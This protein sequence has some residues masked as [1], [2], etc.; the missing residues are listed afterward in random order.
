[1]F[2]LHDQNY[3]VPC[4]IHRASTLQT[5]CPIHVRDE[6]RRV[7][8]ELGRRYA[9]IAGL[10]V[11]EQR[12]REW[13]RLNGL[14]ETRPLVWINEI[15]WSEME[16]EDELTL[17]T[18]S[19]FSKRIE[20]MLRMELYKWEHL[21]ADMVVEPV[22]PSPKIISNSGIGVALDLQSTLYRSPSQFNEIFFAI[23]DPERQ[24][25]SRTV[26]ELFEPFTFQIW[27]ED[28]IEKIQDP[29]VEHHEERTEAFYEAYDE[30]FEGIIDVEP[31]G[32][33]G[34][35]F[36]PWDDIAVFADIRDIFDAMQTRPGYVHALIDRVADA[37]LSALDQYEALGLLATN[38]TNVR[39]GSGGYG[40]ADELPQPDPAEA[41]SSGDIWGAATAQL[42]GKVA[43]DRFAE[44]ALEYEMVWLERFGLSYYGCCESLDEK[45]EVLTRIP[46]LRKV[47]VS[48]FASPAR[49]AEVLGQDY[50]ISLKP[51]PAVLFGDVWEPERAR[52]EIHGALDALCGCR[53]EIL[54]KDIETVRGEPQRLWEWVEIVSEAARQ[55]E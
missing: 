13:T 1:M 8:R 41:V 52:S 3:D 40:Y 4:Y 5:D 17:R 14:E 33:S 50:V 53:V 2:E 24:S 7:L 29:R 27:D 11:Q 39:V 43:P 30:V 47:S 12:A 18:S 20:S 49:A 46:N 35:W 45:F 51:D 48:P 6:D 32:A 31:R 44:F 42:F 25:S 23:T 54:L 55:Y 9:E 21:Q 22:I 34:F 28:D 16:I 26:D 36:A 19:D 15:P 38:N 10:P 37:Y